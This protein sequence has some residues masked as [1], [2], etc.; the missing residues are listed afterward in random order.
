MNK[1]TQKAKSR[2]KRHKLRGGGG[3]ETVIATPLE[4]F[5]TPVEGFVENHDIYNSCDIKIGT[6]IQHK[7]NN[8]LLG[9]VTSIDNKVNFQ[10]NDRKIKCNKQSAIPYV[11]NDI[12][13]DIDKILNIVIRKPFLNASKNVNKNIINI[14]QIKQLK[15][16]MKEINQL[17]DDFG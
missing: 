13:L 4:V 9:Y 7:D 1:R 5:E 10:S 11:Y 6:L 8:E 15:Q 3:T 12:L 14:Q 17:C 16:K 2:K